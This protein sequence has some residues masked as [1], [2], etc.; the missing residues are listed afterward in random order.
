MR[1]SRIPVLASRSVSRTRSRSVLH[2]DMP[3]N[4]SQVM[5]FS[6]GR[7]RSRSITAPLARVTNNVFDS[8]ANE[9]ADKSQRLLS[10][11]NGERVRV[12]S[13]RGAVARCCRLHLP[14]RGILTLMNGAVPTQFL[15]LC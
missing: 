3:G 1:R 2:S 13:V 12:L 9:A 8:G 5:P 15:D 6:D 10:L 14:R 11:Q 7:Y 4:C